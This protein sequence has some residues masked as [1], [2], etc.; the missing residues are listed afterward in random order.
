M[1]GICGFYGLSDRRLL[2]RMCDVISH[3]GPDDQGIYLDKNVGVGNRRLSI[4]DVKGGHQPMHNE[5]QS[6]WIVYNGEI[7]NFK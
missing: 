6:I 4:I 2:K 5:D 1:C 7:Y 3:R